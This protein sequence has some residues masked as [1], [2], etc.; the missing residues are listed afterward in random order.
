MS[1]PLV[2]VIV[3]VFNAQRTLHRC[4]NSIINQTYR[5]IEILLIDDESTDESGIIVDNYSKEDERIVVI[6]KENGGLS[7]ARNCGLEKMHG[8]WVAFVDADDWIE[9]DTIRT[10][11]SNSSGVDIC[12]FGRSKD[13]PS[14]NTLWAPSESIITI[15][16]TTAIQYLIETN[17]IRQ[18]VWDKVFRR[19]LFIEVRFPDGYYYEDIR[20]TYRLIRAAKRVRLLPNIFYHYV[21]NEGSIVHVFSVKNRLDRWTAS[22]ELYN[23]FAG[24]NERYKVSCIR[25]CVYAIFWA[26][27]SLWK[28]D[29][30]E[31]KEER[32]RINEMVSFSKKHWSDVKKYQ[33]FFITVLVLAATGK[34]WSIFLMYMMNSLWRIVKPFSVYRQA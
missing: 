11:I 16:S 20:T 21:Q 22:F 4:V 6:H 30:N 27:G 25:L 24:E 8:S 34:K 32:E 19:E 23:V 18:A 13:S 29:T 26:W 31:L 1:E 5:N 12:G 9:P 7:T 15:D 17:Q 2:S 3:P 33:V 10:V 14:K 28:A